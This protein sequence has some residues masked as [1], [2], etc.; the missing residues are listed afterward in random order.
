MDINQEFFKVLVHHFDTMPPPMLKDM[1]KTMFYAGVA[2]SN[3]I[4]YK[5]VSTEHDDIEKALNT[6]VDVLD[7]QIKKFQAQGGEKADEDK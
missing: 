1:A 3:E 5:A 6:L 2:W 4:W 7:T